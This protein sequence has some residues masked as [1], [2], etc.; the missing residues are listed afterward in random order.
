MT[1]REFTHAFYGGLF[2][3]YVAECQI[4]PVGLSVYPCPYH[5]A[6]YQRLYFGR[7]YEPLPVIEVIER[8]FTEPVPRDEEFMAGGIIYGEIDDA[9]AVHA[10]YKGRL[11]DNAAVVRPTVA[12]IPEHRLDPVKQ[13]LRGRLPFCELIYPGYTAHLTLLIKRLSAGSAEISKSTVSDL[14][15]ALVAA[16]ENAVTAEKKSRC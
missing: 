6:F 12:Q 8:L 3:G 1:G 11:S 5:A 13:D 10:H 15:A 2:P 7:E 9:Q 16:P 4:V 14:R